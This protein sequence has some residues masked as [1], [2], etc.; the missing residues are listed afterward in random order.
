MD[1]IIAKIN[2]I[3]NRVSKEEKEK[4]VVLSETSSLDGFVDDHCATQCYIYPT[5]PHCVGANYLTQRTFK[6]RDKSKCRIQKLISLFAAD[7]FAKRILKNPGNF[8]DTHKILLIDAIQKIREL[9]LPEFK[10][11]FEDE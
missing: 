4:F 9:Y 8:E 7:L 6:T 2:R 11:Y 1:M 3:K 10:D 5:C